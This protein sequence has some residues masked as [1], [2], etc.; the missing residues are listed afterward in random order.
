MFHRLP[1]GSGRKIKQK[2]TKKKKPTHP[3]TNMEPEKYPIGK[4][5]T[6]TNQ[7][8]FGFQPL[9]F[10]AVESWCLSIMDIILG[11][12]SPRCP[13]P[14]MLARG[15]YKLGMASKPLE[16]VGFCTAIVTIINTLQ[17]EVNDHASRSLLKVCE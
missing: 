17:P 5:E 7:Q 6:S 15:L 9:V 16:W 4:G 11:C 14:G 1:G 3:K 2:K 10:R 8:F 12:K 13:P